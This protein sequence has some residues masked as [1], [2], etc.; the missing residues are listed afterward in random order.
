MTDRYPPF[1]LD[2]GGTDLGSTLSAGGMS[3]PCDIR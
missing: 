2:M 1:R 3:E